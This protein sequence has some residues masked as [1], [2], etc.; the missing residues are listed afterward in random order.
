[1]LDP[2]IVKDLEDRAGTRFT[3]DACASIVNRQVARYITWGRPDSEHCVAA[4]VFGYDF[5]SEE[6]VYCNPPWAIIAPVWRHF[7]QCKARG[8]MI[9]PDMPTKSWYTSLTAGEGV[10]GVWTVAVKGQRD[11][12]LQ[13]STSFTASVGPLPWGVLA[14]PFDFSA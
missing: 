5:G 3:I 12:F 1:M 2:I 8:V 4:S 13:P 7:Q 9:V 14:I 10:E 11:V 6:F